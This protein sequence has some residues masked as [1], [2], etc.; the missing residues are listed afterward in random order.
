MLL[1]TLGEIP[2]LTGGGGGGGGGKRERERGKT[3]G[4]E[5]ERLHDCVIFSG[6]MPRIA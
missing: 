5:R 6:Y 4:K 1:D 2:R 3:R